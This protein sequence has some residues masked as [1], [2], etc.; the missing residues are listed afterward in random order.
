MSLHYDDPMIHILLL[1]VADKFG[2]DPDA[3][4]ECKALFRELLTSYSGP[5]DTRSISAWLSEQIPR[6]F[7]S[8]RKRPRW[9]QASDWPFANGKPM[10]FA[11]QIDISASA[12]EQI[13]PNF[14]HDDTSLYV[15][16]GRKVEPVVILQQY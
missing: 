8:L 6:Y 15:F 7:V 13:I 11:G 16:I 5:E 10:V 2:V 12:G 1:R 4:F 9:I 3:S 14:Y